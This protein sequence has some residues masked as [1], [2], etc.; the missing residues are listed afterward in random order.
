[1]LPDS[2]IPVN[3]NYVYGFDDAH[4]QTWMPGPAYLLVWMTGL[5]VVFYLPTHLV[6]RRWFGAPKVVVVPAAAITN[7]AKPQLA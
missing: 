6:L 3:I 7:A 4:P 1:M 2:K 5:L